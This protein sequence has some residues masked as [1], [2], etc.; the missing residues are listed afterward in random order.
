MRVLYLLNISDLDRLS[1]DSGVGRPRCFPACERW[2]APGRT[3]WGYWTA[4]RPDGCAG[5]ARQAA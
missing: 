2:S 1:A 4:C 5:G 3:E